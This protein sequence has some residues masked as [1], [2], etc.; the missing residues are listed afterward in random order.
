MPGTT[1]A[2][3]GVAQA[4]ER[5]GDRL[6]LAG[7]VDDQALARITATWRDRIAVGTNAG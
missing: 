6:G 4:F 7:Q 5:L 3:S 2:P 1:C